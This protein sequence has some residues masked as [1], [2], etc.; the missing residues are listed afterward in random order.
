MNRAEEGDH[1]F[2]GMGWPTS[3][4]CLSQLILGRVSVTIQLSADVISKLKV[5]LQHLSGGTTN[6]PFDVV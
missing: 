5:E 6:H 3:T 2:L 1:Q 4:R